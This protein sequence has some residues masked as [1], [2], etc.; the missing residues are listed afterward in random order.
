MAQPRS[1]EPAQDARDP[2]EPV[3]GERSIE[4]PPRDLPTGS[5]GELYQ[6]IRDWRLKETMR[7]ATRRYDLVRPIIIAARYQGQ[8]MLGRGAMGG[9]FAAKDL[10]LDRDVA[11]K[12][13]EHVR[14]DGEQELM[15][16]ARCMARIRHPNVVT[17]YDLAKCPTYGLIL[18]MELIPGVPLPE[19]AAEKKR[20]WSEHFDVWMQVGRGIQAI[21]DAG[22]V[23]GDIK[24]DNVMIEPK[25]GSVKVIDFGIACFVDSPPAEILGT[26]VY[27]SPEALANTGLT[28]R[29]DQFSFAVCFWEALYG[30]LPFDTVSDD[31]SS[32]DEQLEPQAKHTRGI[33]ADIMPILRLA[34]AMNPAERH[35]SVGAMVDELAAIPEIVERRKQQSRES[36]RGWRGLLGSFALAWVVTMVLAGKHQREQGED[37]DTV[38]Q[39]DEVERQP[40]RGRRGDVRVASA[41]ARAGRPLEAWR[42]FRLANER[43]DGPVTTVDQ[44]LDLAE[45]LLR[46]APTLQEGQQRRDAYDAADYVIMWTI[47]QLRHADWAETAHNRAVGLRDLLAD[48]DPT[49]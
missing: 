41:L 19:W 39:V 24:P 48:S 30:N 21:H 18:V 6:A 3:P 13:I 7:F 34:L 29:S 47:F 26:P 8:K 40:Q 17:V 32:D 20:S 4:P 25:S 35:E 1:P 33:P 37:E 43:V 12:L 16:E 2:D 45:E 36:R 11:L 46:V 9:V 27:I 42:Q 10:E 14:V 23:H 38:T 5:T 44:A 31:E 28:E 49:R 22:I 15:N